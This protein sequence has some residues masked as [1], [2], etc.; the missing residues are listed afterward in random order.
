LAALRF[1]GSVRARKCELVRTD[2]GTIRG[3][4]SKGWRATE[5]ADILDSLEFTNHNPNWAGNPGGEFHRK[6]DLMRARASTLHYRGDPYQVAAYLRQWTALAAEGDAE[7]VPDFNV[8]IVRGQLAVDVSP[9]DYPLVDRVITGAGKLI[10][11]WTGRSGGWRGDA[12]FDDPDRRLLLD[13]STLRA[14]GLRG[15]LLLYV[16]HKQARGRRG[17]G[18]L[19]Q[20]HSVTF[21]ISIPEGGPRLRRVT[22]PGY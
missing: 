12:L 5:V 17:E 10:G 8:G 4:L 13:R 20:S 15:L 6:P 3:E 18:Q 16:I 19:R 7:A 2:Q 11:Q 1:I 9:F 22:V 14:Q 21:G